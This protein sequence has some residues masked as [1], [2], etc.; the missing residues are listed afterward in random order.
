[1]GLGQPALGAGASVIAALLVDSEAGHDDR[2]ALYRRAIGLLPPLC[3]SGPLSALCDIAVSARADAAD[4]ELAPNI[5]D[6][7]REVVEA[8]SAE[9]LAEALVEGAYREGVLTAEAEALL[10]AGGSVSLWRIAP[11]LRSEPLHQVT[12][13]LRGLVRRLDEETWIEALGQADRRGYD[14]VAALFPLIRALPPALVWP[15]AS[16]LL[17]HREIRVRHQVAAFLLGRPEP[18][19][20]WRRLAADALRDADPAIAEIARSAL[21]VN[22]E[23]APDLIELALDDQVP[24][25][26]AGRQRNDLEEALAASREARPLADEE[27]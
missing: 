21:L 25:P 16:Q 11:R 9:E 20:P 7:A 27:R 13:S 4:E 14:A 23:V 15:V 3:A 8:L 22:R 1:M 12:R 5:R 26:A 18:L 19:E 2:A 6:A 10:A 24:C 17:R